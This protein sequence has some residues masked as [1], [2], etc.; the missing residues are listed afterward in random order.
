MKSATERR[1]GYRMVARAQATA[2]TRERILDSTEHLFFTSASDRFSLE[3]VA[4]GAGTTVQTVLRHF[5]SKDFLLSTSFERAMGRVREER[6]SAPVG[7]VQGAVENLVQHYEDRGDVVIR[8]L[9]A[10]DRNPFLHE[11]VDRGREFHRA[12]VA[13]TFAPQL[14]RLG[15]A[16]KRRR[17]AQL[18]AITDVYVWKLLRRDM[19]LG[20][21]ETESAITEMIKELEE[22]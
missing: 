2:A 19:K 13:R 20:R 1:R 9:A 12:W 4:E 10:E 3:D 18:V 17:L 15:G 6:M 22:R 21:G 16:L 7:D 11:V 5:G 14:E 8:W